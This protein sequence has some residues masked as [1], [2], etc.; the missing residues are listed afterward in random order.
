MT[1]DPEDEP[2][3]DPDEEFFGAEDHGIDNQGIPY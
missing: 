3:F 2:D 1:S